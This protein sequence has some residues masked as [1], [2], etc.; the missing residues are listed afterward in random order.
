MITNR[1]VAGLRKWM[2]SLVATVASNYALDAWAATAG[3]TLV[4]SGLLAGLNQPSLVV[5]LVVSYA[6]WTVGLRANLR[7][8]WALLVTTGTSTNIASKAAHDLARRI[9][10]NARV[11]RLAAALGYTGTQLAA[12]GLYYAGAFGAAAFSDAVTGAEALVF[13]AGANLAAVLYEYGL[14]RLT[15]ASSVAAAGTRRSTPISSGRAHP[16]PRVRGGRDRIRDPPG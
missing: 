12:E 5:L 7:A 14:A 15:T 10:S 16:G 8:N 9:T 11:P 4:A 6:A 13:L 1:W 2:V 3:L